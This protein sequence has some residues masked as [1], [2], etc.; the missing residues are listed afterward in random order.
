M[1]TNVKS[2]QG[3]SFYELIRAIEHGAVQIPGD[4]LYGYLE[5]DKRSEDWSLS[6]SSKPF[7][8]FRDKPCCEPAN[9]SPTPNALASHAKEKE[10]APG[11]A[12]ESVIKDLTN[13][14]HHAASCPDD[15]DIGRVAVLADALHRYLVEL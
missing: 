8:R 15:C 11:D 14:I 2:T 13:L 1:V 7:P 6:I 3:N 5:I 4:K 10:M 12:R 9:G